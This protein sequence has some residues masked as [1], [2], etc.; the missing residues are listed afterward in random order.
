MG[1]ETEYGVSVPG[2]PHVNAM[3]TSSQ[4]VTSYAASVVRGA[5]AR[6]DYDEEHPLRDA[7]GF[8]MSRA[9]ADPTQLTDEDMGLANLILTNGSEALQYGSGQG[10]PKLREQIFTVMHSTKQ[11]LCVRVNTSRV[12]WST[13]TTRLL[14]R[15]STEPLVSSV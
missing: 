1:I 5:R 9:E 14:M 6:W 8:D 10:H 15:Q 12:H 3:T 2:H 7:R 13:S 11:S 4:V